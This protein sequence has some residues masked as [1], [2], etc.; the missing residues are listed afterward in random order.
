MTMN[1][2]KTIISTAVAV[3]AILLIVPAI[4]NAVIPRPDKSPWSTTPPC[5]ARIWIA[6]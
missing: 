2:S 4:G 3:L 1:Q 5:F 6:K